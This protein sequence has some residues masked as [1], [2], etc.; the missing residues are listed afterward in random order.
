MNSMLPLYL[1]IGL[2]LKFLLMI[3]NERNSVIT[4][5]ILH[6]DYRII[7]KYFYELF[8]SPILYN[9]YVSELDIIPLKTL[10]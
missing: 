3:P 10:L 6:R 1:L 8:A 2:L 4:L 5:Q 7:Q 9:P